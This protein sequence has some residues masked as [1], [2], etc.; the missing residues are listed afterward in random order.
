MILVYILYI[1]WGGG[2]K[3]RGYK[4]RAGVSTLVAVELKY[5]CFINIRLL[6]SLYRL[7]IYCI[8]NVVALLK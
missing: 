2:G 1:S 7:N 6:G 3:P 4:P 8:Y 5:L